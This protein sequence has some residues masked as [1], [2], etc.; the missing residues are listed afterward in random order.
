MFDVLVD[1]VSFRQ[2]H[3][4]SDLK[5]HQLSRHPFRRGVAAQLHLIRRRGMPVLGEGRE[6][7]LSRET[8]FA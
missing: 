5:S 7:Y 1:L 3:R 6:I 2:T 8:G 4:I